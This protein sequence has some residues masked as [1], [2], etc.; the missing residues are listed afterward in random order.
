M[1][2]AR[3]TQPE[4]ALDTLQNLFWEQKY[5]EKRLEKAGVQV[6]FIIKSS[7]FNERHKPRSGKKANS[8]CL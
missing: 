3:A 7:F 1:A 6:F 8:S 5:I 2:N 4:R